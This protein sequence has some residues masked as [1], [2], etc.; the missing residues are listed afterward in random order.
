MKI[1]K[2]AAFSLT[3]FALQASAHSGGTDKTRGQA[4]RNRKLTLDYQTSMYLLTPGAHFRCTAGCLA[5]IFDVPEGA[6][7]QFS[8]YCGPNGALT[9]GGVILAGTASALTFMTSPGIFFNGVWASRYIEN[10][11]FGGAGAIFYRN[12]QNKN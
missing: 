8:M 11:G 3:L 12:F 6:G 7:R 10:N 9:F 4:P 1:A 5:K 2:T